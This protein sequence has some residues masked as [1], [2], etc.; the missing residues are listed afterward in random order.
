MSRAVGPEE[1]GPGQ[2][3]P[4]QGYWFQKRGLK[5]KIGLN[6]IWSRLK[7][8]SGKGLKNVASDN[9]ID[10]KKTSGLASKNIWASCPLASKTR[11]E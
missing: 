11:P 1:E 10:S 3:G 9:K 6:N 7:K 4:G 2:G 5:N 8:A